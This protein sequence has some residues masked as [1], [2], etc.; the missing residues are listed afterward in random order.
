LNNTSRQTLQ[1]RS[2]IIQ[3]LRHYFDE[4]GFMEVET[5]MYLR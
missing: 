4:R 1:T 5:R 3:Y 2:K